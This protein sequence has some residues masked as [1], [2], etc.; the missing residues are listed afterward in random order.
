[1]DQLHHGKTSLGIELAKRLD[2]E[3]ISADSM[4]IYKFM[5]IGTAKP[6][7]EEQA[8]AKHHMIDICLPNEQFSVA[9]YKEKATECIKDIISRGKVP[10]IVGGTGLY[11]DALVKG[12]EFFPIG[13]DEEYR[14]ELQDILDSKG[15][16]Y[17]FGMLEK[18]DPESAKKID[19]NNIRRVIRALEIYKITGKPK[20]FVDRESVKGPSF[21]YMVYGLLWNR[22]ELYERINKRVDIMLSQG[23]VD[24]VANILNTYGYSKTAM[25]GLGYKEVVDYL[26]K[27]ISYDEM[28]ER[29]KKESRRYAKRQMTWFSHMDYVEWIENKENM[30]EM[31]VNNYQKR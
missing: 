28:V 9:S 24:E 13:T 6:T 17:L 5:D 8:Q 18:C 30:V 27:E 31:I 20:S 22:E 29:I 12:I 21:D 26:N 23:L 15:I 19:K 14:L 3:I 11:I 4:Q 2:G 10:I 16:D 1:V 7:K 25:Q